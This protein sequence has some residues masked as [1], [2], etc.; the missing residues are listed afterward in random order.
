MPRGLKTFR[1]A[2]LSTAFVSVAGVAMACGPSGHHHIDGHHH[3]DH[4]MHSSEAYGLSDHK[5]FHKRGHKHFKSALSPEVEEA[6]RANPEQAMKVMAEAWRHK[7]RDR[8]RQHRQ[9]T[10]D[11]KL[12]S[13]DVKEHL[14]KANTEIQKLVEEMSAAHRDETDRIANGLHALGDFVRSLNDSLVELKDQAGS[15]DTSSNLQ[16]DQFYDAIRG[17][18]RDHPEEL[19]QLFNDFLM[20]QEDSY[21]DEVGYVDELAYDAEVPADSFSWDVEEEVDEP[22]VEWSVHDKLLS[23]GPIPVVGNEAGDV[24]LTYFY[25][26][27]CEPCLQFHAQVPELLEEYPN[28]NVIYRDVTDPNDARTRLAIASYL[29]HPDLFYEFH[30]LLVNHEEMVTSENA[31]TLLAEFFS[32]EESG[33]IWS[34]AF[35]ASEDSQVNAIMADNRLFAELLEIESLPTVYV[36]G[37]YKAYNGLPVPEAL[38]EDIRFLTEDVLLESDPSEAITVEEIVPLED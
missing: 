20:E 28:L 6:I 36:N 24:T 33:E 22:E 8:A 18:L 10:P 1:V 12:L 29:V 27:S 19:R 5:H 2:L 17:F 30:D 35:D 14:E 7:L 32:E 26:A 13:R 11:L 15:A 16:E 21:L 38:R 34:Y 3:H 37:T 25:T 4:E 9:D 31:A 23:K